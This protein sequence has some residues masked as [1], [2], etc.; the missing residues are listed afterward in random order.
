[1]EVDQ[2]IG[3]D[4]RVE[5]FDTITSVLGEWCGNCDNILTNLEHQMSAANRFK[6][7]SNVAKAL[8][9]SKVASVKKSSKSL[10]EN[11]DIVMS[12]L[13]YGREERM[14]KMKRNSTSK[15]G[16]GLLHK[17]YMNKAWR[18]DN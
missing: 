2:T 4:V 13:G 3:R 1:M 12:E 15:V 7:D 9:D 14:E 8:F 18:K 6:E 5:D 11:E 16:K 10:S 17:G